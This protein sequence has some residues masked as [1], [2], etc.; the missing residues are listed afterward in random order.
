MY[1]HDSVPILG[2]ADVIIAGGTVPAVT[3]ASAA[4]ARGAR[5][6]L[7]TPWTY[8]GE[9]FA[10]TYRLWPTVWKDVFQRTGLPEDRLADLYGEDRPA[11]RLLSDIGCPEEL[12]TEPGFLRPLHVKH[13]LE[14]ELLRQGVEFLFG[15]FPVG[16]LFDT[17]DRLAGAAF[18]TRSG[19]IGV[20]ASKVVDAT[21]Y[22]HL[23][24]GVDTGF[25][26]ELGDCHTFRRIVIGGERK[27]AIETQGI[28]GLP[29][30]RSMS[31]RDIGEIA[32]EDTAYPVF[33][34]EFEIETGMGRF[35]DF[36]AV[37]QAARTA[38]WHPGVKESSDMLHW[39][40]P[41][42][43]RPGAMVGMEEFVLS[44]RSGNSGVDTITK[45][46]ACSTGGLYVLGSAGAVDLPSKWLF[47][48]PGTACAV[49]SGFGA[50]V[51][52]DR[53]QILPDSKGLRL[54]VGQVD[55]FAAGMKVAA[56]RIRE[57]R[58]GIQPPLRRAERKT[59][60]TAVVDPTSYPL[61]G[62]VQVMVAGGGTGG[63]PAGVSAVRSGAETLVCEYLWT[64]GGVGT[65]GLIASYYHGYR[66]GFTNEI[67]REVA[68]LGGTA[69]KDGESLQRWDIRHK[70][71]WYRREILN[72]GGS[73]WFGSFGFGALVKDGSVTGVLVAGPAGPGI[74]L[75]KAV[76][77]GTG[78]ADIAA[79]AGAECVEIAGDDLAVQGTGLS[80]RDFGVNSKNTD[81]TFSDDRDVEDV[82]R[83]F[84]VSRHKYRNRYDLSQMLDTRERRQIVGDLTVSPLD[85]YNGRTFS[86]TVVLCRSNFDSHGFTIF[87][88]FLLKPPDRDDLDAW[89]PLRSLLP[90]GLEMILVTGLG[91]SAHR[92]AMPVLRMQP[93]IQNQGY[94]AGF[95]AAKAAAAG[96]PIRKLDMR[97]LQHHLVDKEIVPSDVMTHV[98]SPPLSGDSIRGAVSAVL[99]D[100]SGVP[101]LL[102][103]PE[104]ALPLLRKA[105]EEAGTGHAKNTYAHVLAV[106]GDDAGSGTLVDLVY[107]SDWD[108][109]W[110]FKGMGQ[111]GRTVSLLDSYIIA[112]GNTGDL[113][114]VP[115]ILEKAAKLTPDSAF[116]HFRAVALALEALGDP[117][118]IPVLTKLL[119]LPGVRG[120]AYTEIDA[121]MD[122]IPES[123]TDDSTR[124]LS[125]RELYLA[126]ALYRLGDTEGLGRT[127][128]EEYSKD[129][130]GPYASHAGRVLS[131]R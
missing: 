116:S 61:L 57:V 13:V 85:I 94:V 105:Y 123:D 14:E 118:G 70:A 18:A 115:A 50:V 106:M 12:Q 73:I 37:E 66:G 112:L 10:G 127:V 39:I 97:E 111:F 80:P 36:A 75:C 89:L 101:V 11:D 22:A 99:D 44:L 58:F 19:V 31:S 27:D 17:D 6:F 110:N 104:E 122:E 93:D 46:F 64:L 107:A 124:N 86:D 126:R 67:D 26:V 9:D 108:D 79:A 128:L 16:L 98:D 24:R 49:G 117:R 33:E 55:G 62:E 30:I 72:G 35:S 84:V 23:A 96:I 3:A 42:T 38:T 54:R 21:P 2:S 92:D 87:P 114:G 8:L 129:H 60:N 65:A 28:S 91:I 119:E 20:L 59:E 77:D 74:V 53:S 120:H 69:L 63:A 48:H 29:P 88:G 15:A 40:S 130:R 109:G 32:V 103:N 125:L 1:I 34:Y 90:K 51:G 76:V 131:G 5:V 102:D 121:E 71:E 52:T 78:S 56:D 83:T 82:T 113:E 43:L 4:A 7:A 25:R 100:Y 45:A 68:A 95:A 47:S 81:Y 41:A